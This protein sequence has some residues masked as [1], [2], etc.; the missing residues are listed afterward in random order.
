MSTVD[1]RSVAIVGIGCRFPGG[2][3]DPEQFWSMLRDGRQAIGE[4]PADRMDLQ[5][6]F[7]ETPK[8]PGKTFVRHGGYLKDIA[9]FDPEFFGISPR[10]AER[11]DPQQRLLLETSWDA[12]ENAGINAASLAGAKV[13]VYIGQWQSD[14]EQRL[15][16]HPDEIDF[17]MTLG[18]GRYATS[19]RIAYA[20]GFRG[21]ALTLDTACSSSL[22]AVHLAVQSLRSGETCLALIGGANVILAPHVHIAY[23]QSGM[24]ASDGRCKFGDASADGYVRSEGAAVLVLKRLDAAVREGDR[25]HAVIRGSAI[26]NDGNSSGSMGRPSLLGQ[27]ELVRAALADAGVKPGDVTYVEAH[28]TGTRAGDGVEIGA[29]AAALSDGRAQPLLVGSVKTNIGHTE[30][31]AGTAGLI[32][33]ALAVRHGVIPASLNV[34]KLTP[35]IAWE[36]IPVEVARVARPW[37]KNTPLLAGVSGFGISGANAHVILEAPPIPPQIERNPPL[38]ILPLSADCD[39]ALRAQAADMAAMLEGMQAPALDDLLRFQQTRRSALA[40]RAAFLADDAVELR[41]ALQEF[42]RGGGALAEGVAD[43]SRPAKLAL[44][45][46]GQGGQWPGMARQLIAS[47]PGMRQVLERAEVVIRAESG[48]SLL[49]QINLDPGVEGYLGDRI[50]VVQP[51]LS[52]LSISYAEWLKAHGLQIDAVVGHSMGEAAAAHIAGAIS[53]EDALKIVCRRSALMRQKSGQ[54]A[55]ALV[56]LPEAEVAA[57]CAA[58]EGRVSIA[59]I[60]SPRTSI[61]SGDKDAVAALVSAFNATG[62]FSQ[63]VNVDVASH[64][65]HMDEASRELGKALSGL[66]TTTGHIKFVSSVLARTADSDDLGASYWASNLR[67]PVRFAD[68]LAVLK[69]DDIKVLIELGPHPVLA[70]SIVQMLGDATVVACGRRGEAERPHLF[71]ALAQAW[72]AGGRVEWGKNASHPARVIDI[73]RYPWQRRRLWVETAELSRSHHSAGTLSRGPNEEVRTWLHELAWREVETGLNATPSFAPWLVLGDCPELVAALREAGASVDIAPLADMEARLGSLALGTPQDVLVAASSGAE[74]PFLVLRA[75]KSMQ[76]GVAVRLWFSTRGAQSPLGME[77]VD[78]D[79]A[80]LWGAARV[81]CDERPDL[82]GGLLDVP[83]EIDLS[84]ATRAATFLLA[85]GNEDQV[86][87]R[88]GRA[89]APRIAP[90]AQPSGAALHWRTDSTYLVTGGFGD[91]GLVVARAMVAEGARRVILVGRAGLPNRRDWATIDPASLLGRRIASVH[92]LEALGAS[93]H[94]VSL[95]VSDETAVQQFLED[96]AAEGWPPIRG[97]VHLAAMLDRS[98]IS[99]TTTADFA[100]A[101][102]SKLRSAQVLDRLLPELDCFVL[103]SSMSTF[104]PQP[105]M[106]GYVAANAGL[107]ALAFDRRARGKPASVIVWG[108]WRGIGMIGGDTGDTLTAELAQR[109]LH[110]FNP[111]E[112]AALL[113]WA[114]GRTAPWIGITPIDWAAYAKARIGRSEPLLREVK[115][116]ASGGGLA[117]CLATAEA[118]ER[119]RLLTEAIGDALTRTLQLAPNSVDETREFGAMGLTSLLGMEFRNR[120]ERALGRALPATLAWNF[121]TARALAGHLAGDTEAPTVRAKPSPPIQLRP[122]LGAVAEISD[123]DA[124]AMLRERRRRRVS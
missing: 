81:L 98:L 94:C 51:M 13:G 117:E 21:P 75:A 91:V 10:E 59:A 23:S 77:R 108:H 101:L 119:K 100:A 71:A 69:R 11:M 83:A 52:V 45:F 40:C 68:A 82:W 85:P 90:A 6:H 88:D 54:G 70:P 14:F 12:I 95:D 34:D 80:A 15:S 111:E 120:L 43:P 99:D 46:P 42:S 27:T 103:F 44:V 89:F 25:I 55:M 48:H 38:Q 36:K 58:Q 61:I 28:G 16:L 41:K 114:A 22:Y 102:A 8:T 49:E 110:A 7:H 47:E 62:V 109:G 4:I 118:P 67:E 78:I 17:A 3:D 31:A 116:T 84:S 87:V 19:G 124:V 5:R 33:A 105:G 112:G 66:S 29:L 60:N 122:G 97:V 115:G 9:H 123:A 37:P 86:A 106:V 39:A 104:L 92:E 32:K 96:Y 20:F 121:P 57:A 18:S 1:P 93:V 2:A 35:A 26:N 74:A 53:F 72:C 63:L 64:S 113:S 56:D 50:D 79:Q 76:R 107:E 65:P 30:A 24:M 73:P